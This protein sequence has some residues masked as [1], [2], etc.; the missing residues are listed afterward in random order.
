M[1]WKRSGL[2][3]GRWILVHFAGP[4]NCPKMRRG[5]EGGRVA[6]FANERVVFAGRE[7]MGNENSGGCDWGGGGLRQICILGGC[8]LSGNHLRIWSKRTNE[9]SFGS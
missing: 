1:E 4:E 9:G 8:F 5:D 3:A 7:H 2:G 6:N